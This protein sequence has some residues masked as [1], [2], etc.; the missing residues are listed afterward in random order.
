MSETGEV[1]IEKDNSNNGGNFDA[2]DNPHE[3]PTILHTK[4]FWIGSGNIIGKELFKIF[5]LVPVLCPP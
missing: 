5:L 3:E 1:I 4:K 2:F